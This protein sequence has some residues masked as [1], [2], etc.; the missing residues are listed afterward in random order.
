MAVLKSM[1]VLEKCETELRRVLWKES[2][3]V[4]GEYS[5]FN[6]TVSG[7]IGFFGYNWHK[8]R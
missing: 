4:A 1:L 3:L 2:M 5:L 6:M 7:K 8:G